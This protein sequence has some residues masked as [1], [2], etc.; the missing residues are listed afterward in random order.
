MGRARARL[1]ARAY[2]AARAS[3]TAC[4]G[5]TGPSRTRR[6][7]SS[8]PTTDRPAGG[9][10]GRR[11]WRAAPSI[12]S[13]DALGWAYTRAGRPRA[14]LGWARRALR[15]GSVDPLFRLHA[16]VA[17]RRAGR[18]AEAERYLTAAVK[19]AAA[20]SPA[21]R[22]GPPG[23]A[24]VRRR[25]PHPH[26]G[27][28]PRCWR[29]ALDGSAP[30]PPTRQLLRQPPLHRLDLRRPG[31]GSVRPRPGEIPTVQERGLGRAEVLRRKLAEVDRG[32]VLTVDGRPVALH[33]A[34]SPQLTFPSG[35]GG[36][37]TT[38]LELTLDAAVDGP[39]A[40]LAERRHLPRPRRLEGDRRGTRRGNRRPHEDA[41][42]RPHHRPPHL[43]ARPTRHPP[44]STRGRLLRRTG[45][46][47]LVAPDQPSGNSERSEPRSDGF[48]G[49]F[50]DAADGRGVLAAHAP[51]RLRVGRAPRALARPREGDGRR[52][53]DRHARNV[54]GRARAWR[55]R[56][57]H[58][59]D[60]RLRARARNAWALPVHAP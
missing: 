49:L 13:A 4:S 25:T 3:R 39:L 46:G 29:F 43:S 9:R 10:L 28:C 5:E 47:T 19:G 34:G 58:A 59:H 35:A 51:R 16:G 7:C 54:T 44:R 53:P 31:R 24:I 27:R 12:R 1:G 52:L 60:R 42:R 36:L 57:G 22:A 23:G 37:N 11:V 18:D 14:G 6:R 38:R 41:G 15:T 33:T 21:S 45:P 17:A 2:A 56:D 55:D 8:R 48:A 30:C 26:R 20:L 50:E 40:R 32:L